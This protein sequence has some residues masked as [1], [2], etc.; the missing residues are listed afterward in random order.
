[1]GVGLSGAVPLN[2]NT[3]PPA[4]GE[5]DPKAPTPTQFIHMATAKSGRRARIRS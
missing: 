3:P 1:M 4:K 2:R 5:G